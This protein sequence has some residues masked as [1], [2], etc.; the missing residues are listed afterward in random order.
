VDHVHFHVIPKPD[1]ESGLTV[2]WPATT[3]EKEDLV[4][5]AEEIK[6]KM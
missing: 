1:E 2:G 6:S 5:L 3:P 4:K